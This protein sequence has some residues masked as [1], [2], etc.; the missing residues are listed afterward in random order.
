MD[1]YLLN[2]R[3]LGK[4]EIDGRAWQLVNEF[5][6]SNLGVDKKK[7]VEQIANF[8]ELKKLERDCPDIV[9]DDNLVSHYVSP[10]S[11]VKIYYELPVIAEKIKKKPRRQY[12]IE[13]KECG[14][15]VIVY[16]YRKKAK[17]CS[18]ECRIKAFA[19]KGKKRCAN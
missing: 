10:S 14:A 16:A 5:I 7:S 18:A 8:K 1:F 15:E 17:Y 9:C 6:K 13:C 12:K 11:S 3:E 19:M 4:D 2:R